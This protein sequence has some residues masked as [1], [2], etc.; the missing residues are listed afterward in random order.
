MATLIRRCIVRLSEAWREWQRDRASHHAAAL[1][2]Y[3]IFSLAP[4]VV[5]ATSF[6]T[7]TPVTNYGAL[8]V[9]GAF[10]I[11]GTISVINELQ[12]SLRVIVGQVV[13]RQAGWLAVVKNYFVSF[14]T[15]VVGGGWLVASFVMMATLAAYTRHLSTTRVVGRLLWPSLDAVVSFITVT[16]LFGFIMHSLPARRLRWQAIWQGAVVTAVLFTL[17]KWLISFYI[18]HT[19]ALSVYSTASSLVAFIL[20]VYY[21][22]Q[23][24]LLGV[25]LTKVLDRHRSHL[26]SHH[27]KQ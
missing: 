17:G 5:L 3:S 15:V 9:S 19:A 14:I 1:A 22:A 2:Y 16:V 13:S 4:L 10:V 26:A 27:S 11:I 21:S 8:L 25:E 24:F 18:G 6:T 12:Y 23:I 7:P 20:W